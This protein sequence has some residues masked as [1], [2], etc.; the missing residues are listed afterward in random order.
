MK[1]NAVNSLLIVFDLREQG[2]IN[3]ALPLLWS[4]HAGSASFLSLA[5][6]SGRQ[7][8]RKAALPDWQEYS[9]DLTN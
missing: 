9:S 4:K 8:Y 3:T 6:I 7:N 5:D 2:N 1:S